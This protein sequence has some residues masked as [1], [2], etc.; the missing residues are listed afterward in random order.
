MSK[1]DVDVLIVG[2][3]LSGIGAACHLRQHCKDQSFAILERRQSIGGT[4]DLFR[5]PGIRS[6]SDM[7]T[8]GYSFKPWNEPKVLADGPSIRNYIHDAAREYDVE[9]HI[10]FGRK[11]T[12]ASWSTAEGCWTLTSTDEAGGD[13]Q[14]HRAR[15]VINASGY[16]NYDQGYTPDFPGVESFRGAVIHPQHWP[17]DLDY[18]GKKVVVIGSG[19][20]AITLVPSMAGKAEHVTMLQ[21]SPTYVMS[22]PSVD[23]VTTRLQRF[24]PEK[25][26]YG[27]A[28]ARNIGLQRFLYRV[29]RSR[30]QAV[31]R[32]LRMA[33]RRQL[34]DKVDIK[35]FSPRYNPWDQ[36]LCVVPEGDLFKAL[37]RGTAS[38]V[39]DE[40]ATFDANG[41]QLKSGE[42]LDADIIVTATGLNI[43]MFG[44]A[45]ADVDGQEV[46]LKD[47]MMYRGC[48]VE[49]LP[50]LT[51][52]AGYTNA[53]WTLK[54]DLVN[55]YT[56][57]LI[58]HMQRKN[59][60]MVV[61][62]RQVEGRLEDT[63]MGS[64]ASGYVQRGAD[65]LPRQGR[66]APWKLMN[67]Y[68]RDIPTLRYG[69]IEDGV[70]EFRRPRTGTSA[71]KPVAAAVTQAA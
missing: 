55:E 48:M 20:T 43:Q 66:D 50:N 29:A 63:V 6:D 44:G 33:T 34:G 51:V 15:F 64:L 53:S 21:R 61:P 5:Y 10:H 71:V 59:Y 68:L 70:L 39:T 23:P 46:H 22:V 40:I 49:G 26:A 67:D 27:L 62:P 18:A 28:R 8:F 58:K 24:L 65:Q 9:K 1:I 32:F 31:R 69:R 7:C 25:V 3:G 57:R 30:P 2:A 47:C 45:S 17:E 38:I 13:I 16:Y 14:K 41:I 35:H 42:H 36:R 19:A 56:C 11:V 60:A 12:H 4:W 37:K 54:A 52:I